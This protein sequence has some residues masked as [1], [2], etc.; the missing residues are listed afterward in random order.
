MSFLMVHL[1]EEDRDS[2]CTCIVFVCTGMWP[3]VFCVSI[4]W[5]RKAELVLCIYCICFYQ[6]VIICVLCLYLMVPCFGRQWVIATLSDHT[7]LQF[8]T[9]TCDYGIYCH[10][11]LQ[12]CTVTCDYGIYCHS[13]LHFGLWSVIVVFTVMSTCFCTESIKFT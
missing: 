12:F 13:H 1:A 11:H 3:F 4:S 2:C 5:C 7:F 8:C 9:M 10:I 6:N